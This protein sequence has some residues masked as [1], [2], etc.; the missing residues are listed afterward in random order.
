MQISRTELVIDME[1]I[2]WNEQTMWLDVIYDQNLIESWRPLPKGPISFST[3]IDMPCT[4]SLI[5]ANKTLHSTAVDEQ[6]N[7]V[8]NLSVILKDLR[9]DGIPAWPYWLDKGLE[10]IPADGSATFNPGRTICHNGQIDL[11]FTQPNAF[12]WLAESNLG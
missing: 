9:L 7:I 2:D 6:G 4:V 12:F 11:M 3:A 10:M 5:F 1:S 8:R